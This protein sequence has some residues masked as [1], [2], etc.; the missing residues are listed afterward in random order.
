MNLHQARVVLRPRAGM[1]VL[2]LAAPFCLRNWRLFLPLM[3]LTLLPPFVAC[4]A[5]RYLLHWSWG[6]VWWL[7]I[8]LGG[9]AH[10]PFTVAC[11]EVLFHDARD[12]RVWSV[13][14]RV[15][16]RSPSLLVAH[17]L[18]RVINA[19][20]AAVVIL[21]P[22]TVGAFLVVH[23]AVLLEG[24]GPFVALGRSTR[25]VRGQGMSAVGIAIAMAL[26]PVAA[27]AA[28]EISL[29]TVVSTVLQLGEPFGS[30]WQQGG[31]PYAL[32]GFFAAVPLSAAA[33]F[34]K[35]IDLRTRKEGWDI[36]LRFIS[37]A[38]AP[39]A[40]GGTRAPNEDAA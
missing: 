37:M 30:L 3:G 21:L 5:L 17:V 35:Y 33:R 32:A 10:A 2:D 4:L 24:A 1:D 28:A 40:R 23:E 9:L 18:T 31:T 13:V 34:L 26:L 15:L 14:A 8:G 11:G 29:D 36:Q 39:E 22:F 16:R 27:V 38:M 20:A 7:A 19:V 25:A 6:P 12:V